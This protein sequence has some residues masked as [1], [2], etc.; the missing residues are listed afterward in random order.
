[1][2]TFFRHLW[3]RFSSVRIV[4]KMAL[5][6]ILL[7]VV[8]VITFGYYFFN[9]IYD[10]M[11]N[12]Y[13][14]GKQELIRQAA[15][16][17]DVSIEQVKSVHSLFQYN[18][19]VL[20]YLN[21][22]Y[23]TEADQVY[24]YLKDVRP[25]FS[26]AYL[27]NEAIRS[28]RLYKFDQS[29]LS[30]QGEVDDLNAL[31]NPDILQR[32]KKLKVSQ[33]VWQKQDATGSS[34]VPYFA[35][36]QRLYNNSY[37]KQLAVMEVI[38]DDTILS[39]FMN[40]VKASKG[41]EVM[42]VSDQQVVYRDKSD[43]FNDKREQAV[44]DA[45]SYEGKKSYWKDGNLLVNV[46]VRNDLHLAFYFFSPLDE[47]FLDFRK[48]TLVTGSVL[49]VLL[50]VLSVLYYFIASLLTKRILKLAKHMR[51]V[52]ENNMSLY[53]GE[54]ASDEIGF[55]T[56][57]YNSMI[58]RIDEL[59]NKV[60]KAEL[61]KKEADY[62]VMQAQIKPHFL[63]NTL[64]SIR[65]L[66]EINDD[67]DVVEATYTFGKLLRYTLSSGDNETPLVDEFENIRNYLEMYKLRMLDRLSYEI[68]MDTDISG[69]FCPRFILQPLVENSIHHGISKSRGQ[70]EI[71]VKI[72]E[73]DP[74]IH[75]S[76][77]DNGAGITEERLSI[78]RGVLDNRL[79]RSELQT[80]DS[81]MGLYNVSE[82]IKVYFGESSGLDIYS[83]VG[84]GTLYVVKLLRERGTPN[85]KFDDRG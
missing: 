39:N 17:F 40:T 3:D 9:Q 30:V 38:V 44:L 82:R 54:T 37:S 16:S 34:G 68:H 31:P 46:F 65:M 6:Y 4:R 83:K 10:E 66:A 62:L 80:E 71:K 67:Q 79:D 41:T 69:I 19:Q 12:E 5:G 51:R 81:G 55:L 27:G 60:Q 15:G 61:M 52:D 21:G 77:S 2:K 78:I 1:M 35:Y 13:S 50:I 84:E 53:E 7:V 58:H 64:E 33:G 63:Y 24:N 22:N 28:I 45:I 36:Y 74:F 48:E 14:R 85:A 70:G 49:L 25:A 75:I 47:M 72:T 57:S 43:S 42:I 76:I 56:F 59:L 23:L 29:V 73:A 18:Q 32:L 8:P 11:M 26:F 20:E